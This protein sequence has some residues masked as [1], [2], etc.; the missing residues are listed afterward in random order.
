M[1]CLAVLLFAAVLLGSAH[2]SPSAECLTQPPSL[3]QLDAG[4]L[5]A[6]LHAEPSARLRELGE[7]SDTPNSLTRTFLSPAHRT[8]ARLIQKWMEDAGLETWNDAVGN[9]HG[10]AN[11][12]R[13]DLPAILI[14]SHYDTITDGGKYD[15][16]LGVIVAVAATKS[17]R[18]RCPGVLGRGSMPGA[19]RPLHVV[20]FSDEEGVRF[21]TTF[22]GSKALAGD[23]EGSGAL[24]A[25]DAEGRT[26]REVLDGLVG[27]GGF[28]AGAVRLA[29]GSVEAYVEV[30]G[31]GAGCAGPS[32][33]DYWLPGS[34]MS[35]VARIASYTFQIYKREEHLQCALMTG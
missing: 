15:G 1:P 27:G 34:V 23:L 11:G 7:I 22:L 19:T 25:T 20:A 13:P 33:A 28:D 4:T 35:E 31:R 24:R 3:A 9:V 29:L 6:V 18:L 30:R 8:A 5:H 2:S 17:L 16:A 26:L 10:R 14:G 12:S 21:H 32:L